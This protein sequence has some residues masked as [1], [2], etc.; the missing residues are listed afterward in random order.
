MGQFYVGEIFGF[1]GTFAPL[2]SMFCHGQLVSVAENDALFSLIG[3]TYGGDGTTTFGLPDLRGRVPLSQGQGPGLS[4]YTIGQKA[5]SETVTLTTSQLPRHNHLVTAANQASTATPSDSSYLAN[6]EV[7]STAAPIYGPAPGTPVNL[8]P[9]SV[10]SSGGSLPHNNLQ[11][12]Q[13]I[14]YCI[15]MYGIYPQQS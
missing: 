7:S 6:E 15:A 10:S 14:N 3:T 5:G 12:L 1:S 8:A 11:P 13:V 4:N 9:N 2:G